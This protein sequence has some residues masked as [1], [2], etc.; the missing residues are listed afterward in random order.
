MDEVIVGKH[1]MLG[2]TKEEYEKCLMKE[3]DF[4]HEKNVRKS[5]QLEYKSK[6]DHAVKMENKYHISNVFMQ[7]SIFLSINLNKIKHFL[8]IDD[9]L[10]V[11][12]H[13][14]QIFSDYLYR[15]LKSVSRMIINEIM[16]YIVIVDVEKLQEDFSKQYKNRPYGLI[17]KRGVLN[18]YDSSDSDSSE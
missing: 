17:K 9:V 18:E 10:I 15:H 2:M 4:I 13:T 7:E 5:R 16:S 1:T 3:I 11:G 14:G 6:R 12:K 8:A